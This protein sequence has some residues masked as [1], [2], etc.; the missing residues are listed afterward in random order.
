[1]LRCLFQPPEESHT[2]GGV[3][4]H[5]G[6]GWQCLPWPP[7]PLSSSS[8]SLPPLSHLLTPPLSCVHLQVPSRLMGPAPCS[9]LLLGVPATGGG[10]H[11]P[12]L[13]HGAAFGA[14][15]SEGPEPPWAGGDTQAGG[16][17]ALSWAENRGLSPDHA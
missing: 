8:H 12:P 2:R 1:M 3:G 7:G 13:P 10:G 15:E 5:W 6:K 14:G 4:V 16:P 9:L 11:C 17:L